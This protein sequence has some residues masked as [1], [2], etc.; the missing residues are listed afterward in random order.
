MARPL[1]VTLALAQTLVLAACD[2]GPATFVGDASTTSAVTTTGAPLPAATTRSEQPLEPARADAGTL[3]ERGDASA[4]T[5]ATE[6]GRPAWV[7]KDATLTIVS[8]GDRDRN[9]GLARPA[10]TSIAIDA[11]AVQVD[12]EVHP[13]APAR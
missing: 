1:R 7:P 3:A 12:V 5:G 6:P 10:S 9:L 4:S 11:G 13:G 2:R 8:A